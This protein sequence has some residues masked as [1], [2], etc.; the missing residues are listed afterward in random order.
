VFKNRVLWRIFETEKD[1]IAD[2]QVKDGEIGGTCSKNGRDEKC[3][4]NYGRET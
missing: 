2:D 4:Q 3:V 1:E